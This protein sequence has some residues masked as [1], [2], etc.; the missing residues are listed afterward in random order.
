[1]Y[2][3]ILQFKENIIEEKQYISLEKVIYVL[4]HDIV[5]NWTQILRDQE[6]KF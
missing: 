1:M 3:V 2:V 5:D 6:L 4:V